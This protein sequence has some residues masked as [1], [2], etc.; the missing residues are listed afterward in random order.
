MAN[1]IEAKVLNAL[2]DSYENSKTF[3][4]ENIHE[5]RFKIRP[6]KLFPKYDDDS[7][8]ALY[9]EIN[10]ILAALKAKGFIEYESERSGKIKIVYLEK[11]LIPEIYLYLG[12]K[13]KLDI[14][15]QLL[16][17]WKEYETLNNSDYS[18]LISYIFE[19]RQY[20]RENKK[21]QFFDG[22]LQEYKDVLC[23]VKFI[24]ENQEEVFIREFSVKLF[25]NSKRLESIETT[26]RALLYNFGEYDDKETVLEEHNI[27]KT[28]TYV[29]V[30]SCGI[31][32]FKQEIDLSKI[33]GDIGL[34]TKTLKELQS[35]DLK[36]ANVITIENLTSFHKYQ[37]QNEMVIYLGGFHN[38][39]KRDFI[40]LV[41][42]CNP[43]TSFKHFGDI[44]AGG[45]YILE[46][47]K[48]KTGVDFIPHKMD[49]ET[50]EE[51]KSHWIKLTENDKN[52]LNKILEKTNSYKDTIEY[53][54]K[55]NCK[56]EQES[57]T[58][59]LSQ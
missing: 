9:K 32:K 43:K 13:S 16:E 6:A 27:I 30:K 2:L 47:L 24:L 42:K 22:D 57:I 5:Q 4:G 55:N 1:K 40:K 7:E 23:A 39:V 41:S 17:I 8:Y 46:H 28:P 3:I 12:R 18:S 38:S 51:N 19:Q 54:F 31:L 35:V 56:L 21:I 33:D 50:L 52:R 14:N 49:I 34:S 10:T 11:S 53:M 20:I 37:P 26:V 59:V 45:F 25:N 15:N 29:M 58:T 44:D 36:G 48:I